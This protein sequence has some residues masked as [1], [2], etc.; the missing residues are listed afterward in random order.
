MLKRTIEKGIKPEERSVP[1]LEKKEFTFKSGNQD[2]V[3]IIVNNAVKAEAGKLPDDSQ[4]PSDDRF[5]PIRLVV[6]LKMSAQTPQPSY[7]ID[8]KVRFDQD[9]EKEAGGRAKLKLAY[10]TGSKWT[11]LTGTTWGSDYFASVTIPDFPS[12]PP[13]ATG[14]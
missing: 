14:H 12:D 13:L 3:R 11:V 8:L 9:D 7:A 10:L 1:G 2:H 6:N 5:R 4:L